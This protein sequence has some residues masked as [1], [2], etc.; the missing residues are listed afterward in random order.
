LMG[1][2]DR[3]IGV[4]VLGDTHPSVNGHH[5]VTTA[6][7]NVHD[8]T[9]P[10]LR[11]LLPAAGDAA[12]MTSG[13]A[14]VLVVLNRTG[15]IEIVIPVDGTGLATAFWNGKEVAEQELRP[16]G[17]LRFQTGELRRGANDLVVQAAPGTLVHPIRVQAL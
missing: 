4:H 6:T 15:H 16:R 3:V 5:D 14:Q 7:I 1:D 2:Y 10:L 13:N 8:A 17:S 11:G 12:A 9:S